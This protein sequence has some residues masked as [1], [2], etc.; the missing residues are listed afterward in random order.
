MTHSLGQSWNACNETNECR[1]RTFTRI[2]FIE[3]VS[4]EIL[5]QRKASKR[6]RQVMNFEDIEG[7]ID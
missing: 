5:A 1:L 4:T 2:K 7:I 6:S 3:L